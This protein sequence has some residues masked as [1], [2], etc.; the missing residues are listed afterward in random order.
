V[1]RRAISI[2]LEI[3]NIAWVKGRA[4]AAG[5]SVSEMIDQ[6]VTAARQG[7]RAG[8]TRSVVG[9]IDV[10]ASDP[11]LDHADAA[12]RA[13]FTASLGRP[14]AVR[15]PKPAYRARPTRSPKPRG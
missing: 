5:E 10:D 15:E 6:L 12:V 11:L 9:T 1:A 14:F 7:H 13:A 3:D 2:T 8:Q 4:G